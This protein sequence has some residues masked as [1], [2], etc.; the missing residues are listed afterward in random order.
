M[1]SFHLVVRVLHVLCG[2]I[3]V[4]SILFISWFLL[5]ALQ[6]VGPAGAKV[7]MFVQKRGWVVFIPIIATVTILS[8]F[9][10][11]RPYMANFG[12][13]ASMVFGSGA[14]LG[15]ISFL[16]GLAFISPTV[17]RATLLGQ[18]AMEKPEGPERGAMMAQAQKLRERASVALRIVSILLVV[19][20]LFMAAGPLF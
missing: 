15:T 13:H 18:S 16:V 3:W 2:A 14:I 17:A 9:W 11:Y 6:D 19:T 10:L 7:M 1:H 12:S 4:G 8:G 5:P 20:V